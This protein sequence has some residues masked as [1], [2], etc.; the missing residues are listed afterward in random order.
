MTSWDSVS[1]PALC[2]SFMHHT[3]SFTQLLVSRQLQSFPPLLLYGLDYS[4]IVY[5]LMKFWV[6]SRVNGQQHG[7]REREQRKWTTQ[8][9]L[10]R[11]IVREPPEVGG[12]RGK[13]CLRNEGQSRHGVC[14]HVLIEHKYATLWTRTSRA[15]LKLSLT[16][17]RENH[18]SEWRC[19]K[20]DHVQGLATVLKK[21]T[22]GLWNADEVSK[23]QTTLHTVASEQWQHHHFLK[24]VPDL[25]K[26]NTSVNL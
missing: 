9:P 20:S 2:C 11:P 18:K 7:E 17:E 19:V 26:D 6:L 22:P 13:W 21:W 24:D 8:E 5:L 4:L 12:M 3:K 15:P 23:T 1:M 14:V 25:S 10:S 16:Y